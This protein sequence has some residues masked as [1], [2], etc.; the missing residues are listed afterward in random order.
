MKIILRNHQE[1]AHIWAAQSQEKG[2]AGNMFFEGP[3]IFSYGHHFEIARHV[4]NVILFTNRSYSISTAKH[5]NYTRCAVS[6]KTVFTVPSMTDHNEN[7]V[8]YLQDVTHSLSKARRA[9]Y[10]TRHI[11]TAKNALV[12]VSAYVKHFREDIKAELIAQVRGYKAKSWPKTKELKAM[13]AEEEEF[14]AGAKARAAPKRAAEYAR[15]EKILKRREEENEAADKWAGEIETLTAEAFRNGQSIPRSAQPYDAPVL[16]RLIED[17]KTIETSQGAYVPTE[18]A[19][20]LWLRLQAGDDIKGFEIGGY[21]V[22]GLRDGKLVIGCHKIPVCEVARMAKVL[23]L[24][25]AA[26]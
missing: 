14:K 4:G 12:E 6:H 18:Q 7:V 9:R 3:S 23:G 13:A 10:S 5:K 8:A 20:S 25:T 2:R 22:S 1:V 24:E 21:K 17:G 15:S 19:K 26:A 11:Q 16:L